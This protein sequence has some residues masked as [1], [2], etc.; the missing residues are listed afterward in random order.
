MCVLMSA[1]LCLSFSYF[2]DICSQYIYSTMYGLSTVRN[3]L[4]FT[5]MFFMSL[6][7][8]VL[9][10]VDT[11]RLNRVDHFVG[12]STISTFFSNKDWYASLF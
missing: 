1:H 4:P 7:A 9:S 5:V 10:C 3:N 2:L 6:H 12:S 11:L 8:C